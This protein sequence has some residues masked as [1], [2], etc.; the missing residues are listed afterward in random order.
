MITEEEFSGGRRRS[1]RPEDGASRLD[2][3]LPELRD[4]AG[5][6]RILK[7]S[8]RNLGPAFVS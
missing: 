1:L 7:V 5:L 3:S 6:L 2:G 8:S 4:V